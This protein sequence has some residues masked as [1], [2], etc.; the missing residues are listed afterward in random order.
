MCGGRQGLFVRKD[1]SVQERGLLV[2]REIHTILRE[3][4]AAGAGVQEGCAQRGDTPQGRETITGQ[5]RRG[6]VGDSGWGRRV[7]R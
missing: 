5:K 7:G 2:E 6:H 3:R 4:D 1:G